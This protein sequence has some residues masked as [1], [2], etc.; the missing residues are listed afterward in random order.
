MRLSPERVLKRRGEGYERREDRRIEKREDR[1]EEGLERRGAKG[2]QNTQSVRQSRERSLGRPVRGFINTISGG[3]SGKTSSSERKQHW[4]SIRTINH[5]FKKR[6]LPPMLFTDE[7]FQEIDPDHDDP[8]VIT[9]EIAEY[10][11]MKTLVDQGSSVDILFWDT[12]KRLHLREEDIVPFREQIIGFSGERVSTKGYIDLMTTF[13][14]SHKTKTIKIRYL[15]VD[16]P[17][18]YNVLLGRSS[19]NKLGAIVSTP[20]LAMKFP[21]EKGE[22]ATIYVNQ[23]DARECYA[24]GLKMNLQ[25]KEGTERMV[26]M[27]D[28]DPR[29]NDERLEPKEETT[30]IALGRD[31]KQCTY[32][33]GSLP[34]ELLKKLITLL[35]SNEDLFAW[36]PSDIPG[37]NPEIICHKLSVCREARPISQKRRRL[38]E[39]RRR[40]AIEETE[41][42]MQAGFIKEAHYTTWLSNVV[43]VK[44]PNGK[45]RM[46]T[47]YTDLNKACPKDTYPLPS[48]DRLIDGVSGQEMMSFLDAYSGYNQIQMYEPDIPKTAFAT[49]VANYCYKVMPFGLKNAGAT[50]QRL[51]D[52]VFKNQIGKNMEIYID[53]M[54]VKSKEE[55]KH[56]GDLEEVFARIREYNIRLNPE[57]CVFGVKGGK[58]LGF[59]LTNRGIEANPD[60]CEAIMKMGS[61]KNL[62]EVQRLVGKLNSLSR[63]LPI[64]AQKTKPIVNLLKKSETFEWNDKC[65]QSF[66]QIKSIIAQPPILVKPVTTQPIIVYLATSNEAIGAALIQENPEQKP[67]YFVSRSL[68]SAETR[69]PKVDKVALTLVYAARRFRPYFQNHQIIVRTDY[70]ISKILRKPELAGRMV[71]WSIELSEYGIKYEPRGPIKA[72][73]LADFIIQMP[74]NQQEQWTLYVDGASS[75]KGSGAGIVLEGPHNFQIEMALRF[76]FRTSNNQAEY[77]AL[78]AGL[79]LARDMGAENILCKSDS[80]L[81]IGHLQGKYQVK[82]PLLMKYYHNVLSIMQSF[83]TAEMQYIPR[84]L[85]MKADSLSKLASQQRQGQHNSIIQQTQSQPT[86]SLAECFNVTTIKDEWIKTY[87]ETI[88]NQEQGV[89]PDTKMAKKIANFVLIGD[90]LYKRGYST[91][92]LKCLPK[93]QAEYVVKELH[94]GICGLHCGARTMATRVCRAGY[95]W[96]TIREDC[97]FYVKTCKKC[98][99]FGNLNRRPAQEL[100]G[101]ISPWPF[102][103]WGIDILGP[104]PL[105]RGQTKFMIVAVD[106]FTKWIEAEA[107]TTI[108]AQQVQSFIWKNIICRFGI[109]HTIISDNGRQ[110]VD[111]KLMEFYADL[112]IKSTNTSV[113]HPQT[114]GQ[115][116]AANKIIL[117]QLKKRLGSAKGLWAEKLPEILWAYR[118]TPQTSTGETPFNLTYGTDA[119]LPV[120]VNEPTLRRQMEDW[121]INNECLRTDL[122]LIEELRERAK[123]KEA[124]VKRRAMKRFNAKVKP[125]S[126]IEGDLVW[127]MR[128]DAR[129]DPR[130]GKLAS[131]WEGPFRILESLHNGAYRLE[132]LEE[133]AIPN[134]WNASHLKFYFS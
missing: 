69:Y 49:D 64:L 62:K 126:F 112:G 55:G 82:D 44:K 27:A 114:N 96:P 61:P 84:E 128:T 31:E 123:I 88:K 34:E 18:S 45:W 121:N 132:T 6:T 60:K 133:K 118:C 38:G 97:E 56:L 130:H 116:E 14:K 117:G 79:L 73:S 111:K 108:T 41:K 26:A 127:R 33:S 100:Q 87:T 107:L 83:N 104:F 134:T 110:F 115:V 90:D 46:C 93:E 59:M 99:E 24:T 63:F 109:P 37:I 21:T 71:T 35:R 50:Y 42:L 47:D 131:N 78:V 106:Y 74:T 8:M 122:D 94:E 68:Q 2:Y 76:E 57:K 28:L 43:L 124:A 77:E 5:I 52:R 1:R 39:E 125:R 67:I 12:F 3:F 9:V 40:A 23:K 7:D 16:A 98:Q 72:Q 81:S 85:N 19:L 48:I 51:M 80:Q 92:L 119:M 13:G 15:V 86:V 120:E 70:P 65:E 20:H 129:K 113:E 36:T 95:Y 22:I 30:A 4:R 75:K 53:D 89:E 102:A 66:L 105:G 103:K 91:P 32:I 17:T 11:V 25:T 58:F 54:V 29:W 101:I 10:A